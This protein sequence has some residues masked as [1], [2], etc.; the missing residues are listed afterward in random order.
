MLC[1]ELNRSSSQHTEESVKFVGVV[2][3]IN[4]TSSCGVVSGRGFGVTAETKI[5]GNVE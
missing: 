5:I 4:M 1:A 2:D 3:D